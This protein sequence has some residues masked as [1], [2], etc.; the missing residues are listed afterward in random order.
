MADPGQFEK[1]K[2]ALGPAA[3]CPPFEQLVR[4]L[5]ANEGDSRRKAAEAHTAAC[6]HCRACCL[7]N[8]IGR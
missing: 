5:E 7:A 3:D 1:L 2:S 4:A 6:A 8:I